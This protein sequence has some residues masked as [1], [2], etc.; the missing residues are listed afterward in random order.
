MESDEEFEYES[1]EGFPDE[2]EVDEGAI[3]IENAFYEADDNKAQRP[4]EALAQFERVVEMETARRPEVVWRFKALQAMVILCARLGRIFDMTNRYKALL[5]YLDQVTRNDAA[6]AINEVLDAVSQCVELGAKKGSQQHEPETESEAKADMA[7]EAMAAAAGESGSVVEVEEVY[8]WTLDALQKSSNHR[9]WFNTSVRLAKLYLE[10]ENLPALEKKVEE[11]HDLC[12][13]AEGK[14]DL[15]GKAWQLVEVYS[16]ELQMCERTGN[17]DRMKSLYPTA[18]QL[19]DSIGDPRYT[20]VIREAGAQLYMIQEEWMNAY[21]EFLQ[22]FRSYQQAGNP[23]RARMMLK[24]AFAAVLKTRH[25]HCVPCTEK[26]IG[27]IKI[28]CFGPSFGI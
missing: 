20:A 6:E 18:V 4:E 17:A 9:L 23:T 1:E 16:L 12:R 21:D 24:N 25:N 8:S 3:Q 2:E 19:T 28:G 13:D 14:D 10:R 5:S 7:G 11:L 27:T 26:R 15:P 22:A